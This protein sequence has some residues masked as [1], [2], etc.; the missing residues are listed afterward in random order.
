MVN[1]S[2]K[3]TVLK[4]TTQ[5]RVKAGDDHSEAT[6]NAKLETITALQ[7]ELVCRA[8]VLASL[9][10]PREFKYIDLVSICGSSKQRNSVKRLLAEESPAVAL[11]F[12]VDVSSRTVEI[13]HA[14]VLSDEEAANR[15]PVCAY[16]L[17]KPDALQRVRALLPDRELDDA[18]VQEI[19]CLA[20]SLQVLI[21]NMPGFKGV[22]KGY[23][24]PLQASVAAEDLVKSLLAQEETTGGK[25]KKRKK[26][27]K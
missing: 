2:R 21:N 20:Y 14:H 17:T 18:S 26:S 4:V 27:T 13:M 1:Q 7:A 15:S 22:V 12:E 9:I 10:V 5:E 16:D 3:L 6:M 8:P 11:S 25:I 23:S 24:L 19:A